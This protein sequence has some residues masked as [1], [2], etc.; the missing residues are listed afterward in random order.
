MDF[1]TTPNHLIAGNTAHT[2]VTQSTVSLLSNQMAG[3]SKYSFAYIYEYF[4]K[5]NFNLHHCYRS[6]LYDE[7]L[8]LSLM[9]MNHNMN[10][11]GLSRLVVDHIAP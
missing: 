4:L 2:V 5:F 6:H 9:M 3:L 10:L 1:G 11:F 8:L 7:C